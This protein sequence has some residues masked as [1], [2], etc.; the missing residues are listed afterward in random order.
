LI[1]EN[2]AARLLGPADELGKM[3]RAMIRSLQRKS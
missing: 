2:D 3:L 1:L